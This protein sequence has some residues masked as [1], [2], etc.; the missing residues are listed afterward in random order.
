[1]THHNFLSGVPGFAVCLSWL[2]Q[3][4]AVCRFWPV[5]GE[6]QKHVKGCP[7]VGGC[8]SRGFSVVAKY[9]CHKG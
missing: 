3:P 8:P 9:K 6:M 2:F 4:W 1:M 5:A 7:H